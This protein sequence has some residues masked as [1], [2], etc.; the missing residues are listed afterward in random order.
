ML[1]SAQLKPTLIE[2]AALMRQQYEDLRHLN[3]LFMEV[4]RTGEIDK[5]WAEYRATD[6]RVWLT[7][8]IRARGMGDIKIG[9]SNQVRVRVRSLFTAASR[10][11][12]LIACY[13]APITHETELHA[14][15]EHLRLCGEW[16]R[17]GRELL[18]HLE[19]VGCDTSAFTDVVP[20]HFY[21]Q[22]PE[23]MS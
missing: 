7:Y 15:F 13:P 19:L 23:R 4:W 22:F 2:A 8:F 14:E 21:R 20:A 6:Q 12:D 1:T 18:S 5:V 3:T 16:F 9:K 11:I 10:G 17:P